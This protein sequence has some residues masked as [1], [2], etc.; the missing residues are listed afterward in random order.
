LNLPISTQVKKRRVMMKSHLNANSS[1]FEPNPFSGLF[2]SSNSSPSITLSASS[3]SVFVP[4]KEPS[5]GTV[6]SDDARHS[7]DNESNGTED[8]IREA[9]ERSHS[10]VS[11]SSDEALAS[12]DSL[13]TTASQNARVKSPSPLFLQSPDP[14][15]TK[16]YFPFPEAHNIRPDPNDL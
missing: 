15:Y 10:V 1:V 9:K 4:S 11:I 8:V 14:A 6:S 3:G 13:F 5:Y 16:G 12:G 7:S 2:V